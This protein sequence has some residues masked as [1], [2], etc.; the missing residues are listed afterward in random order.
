[1]EALVEALEN[2]FTD[3]SEKDEEIEALKAEVSCLLMCLLF[4]NERLLATFGLVLRI[5][6]GFFAW[7]GPAT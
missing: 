6:F 7:F 1:M 5:F 3:R 4:R 2:S